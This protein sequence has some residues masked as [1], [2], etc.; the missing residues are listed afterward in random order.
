[1]AGALSGVTTIKT[2]FSLA[3]YRIYS[4]ARTSTQIASDMQGD[5]NLSDTNLKQ[6]FS[7]NNT[8][9]ND[10]V[11]LVGNVFLFLK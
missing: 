11:S 7:F 6:H 4:G 2:G 5:I 10:V 8:L 1:M 3:D 9:N